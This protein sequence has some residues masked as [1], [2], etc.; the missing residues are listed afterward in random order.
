MNGL[1]CMILL[2]QWAM[3]KGWTDVVQARLTRKREFV[4]VD[5][6]RFSSDPRTYEMLQSP[7]QAGMQSPKPE[8]DPS[9]DSKQMEHVS[10]AAAVYSTDRPTTSHTDREKDYFGR[11]AIYSSPHLSFS[12]PRAPSSRASTTVA[13]R[14]WDPLATQ[15]KGTVAR[16]DPR[17]GIDSEVEEDP[18]F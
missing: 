12:S 17:P 2:G 5:A 13:T 4:S 15:A 9:Q 16:P 8:H 18:T 11:E 7:P 14:E 6:R 10:P 3:I 1:W